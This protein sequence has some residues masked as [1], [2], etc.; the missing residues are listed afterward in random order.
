MAT[1]L[2]YWLIKILP[3]WGLSLIAVS[4][5]YLVP[6]IYVNNKE[7]IDQQ[8]QNISQTVNSQATQVKGLAEHHTARATETV[9][10]YA[11]D[12]T[13]K[14]QN[15]IG[16]AKARA[17]SPGATSTNTPHKSELG[18]RQASSPSSNSPLRYDIGDRQAYT[19][20]TNSP[21]R[22]DLGDRP[23]YTSSDFPHAPKQELSPGV[24]SHEQQYQQS[25]FGGQ[26]EPAY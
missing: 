16:A 15:Y 5:G 10:A 4:I 7:I 1:F 22:S 20:S 21:L 12:Y 23:A 13:S 17:T 6:L 8:L 3:L 24:T 9:K 19:A 2:S 18:D 14:A 11:G 25:Q 26:A